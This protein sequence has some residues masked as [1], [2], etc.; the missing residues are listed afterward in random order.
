MTKNLTPNDS[1][2]KRPESFN[3]TVNMTHVAS[4]ETV[5]FT[6]AYGTWEN[7]HRGDDW[8]TDP[9]FIWSD[10][11]FSCNCN[12]DLFFWRAK[13]IEPEDDEECGCLDY[14]NYRVNWMRNDETGNI[15]YEESA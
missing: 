1:T 2:G 7:Y 6:E 15:I 9:V 4:G 3:Y 8:E 13:G 12:R 14:E 11:N 10:G 5:E